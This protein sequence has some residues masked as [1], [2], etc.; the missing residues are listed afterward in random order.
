MFI[1]IIWGKQR[2]GILLETTV[3][4]IIATKRFP[5]SV[6][7]MRCYDMLCMI[8]AIIAAKF[9][10]KLIFERLKYISKFSGI[11]CISFFSSV[12]NGNFKN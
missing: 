3:A 8:L 11:S 7:N 2:I 1:S 12:L 9:T 6:P 4:N 10:S 5:S